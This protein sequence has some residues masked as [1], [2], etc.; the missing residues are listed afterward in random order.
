[1]VY[2]LKVRRKGNY[3]VAFL[4]ARIGKDASITVRAKVAIQAVARI[5]KET[6]QGR[7]EVGSNA[8]A[9]IW[10]SAKK[11]A[12]KAAQNKA[13]R[14]AVTMLRHPDL[15]KISKVISRE[16]L[17]PALK[18]IRTTLRAAEYYRIIDNRPESRAAKIARAKLKQAVTVSRRLQ[19]AGDPR[20]TTL[21]NALQAGR[22][23]SIPRIVI[24]QSYRLP[25]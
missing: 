4:T 25:Q 20:G 24:E 22:K 11:I 5:L 16:I 6:Y 3:F 17:Y 8:F 7:L 13:L 2:K 10:E 21:A 15:S 1:M 19:S 12:K 9:N 14:Q 18:S 23:I